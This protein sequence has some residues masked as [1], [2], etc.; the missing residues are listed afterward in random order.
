MNTHVAAKSTPSGN[1]KVTKA[2]W[3]ALALSVLV[4]D[5]VESVRIL[6]LSEKLK[7]SRSSFYW[8]FASHQDLLDQLLTHWREKNTRAIIER[9]R[10]AATTITHGVLNVFECWADEAVFSPRLDFAIREWAR[11]SDKARQEIERADRE[12][13]EAIRD[14]FL[15]HGFGAEEAFIRAR[16]LYYMQIGY[17]VL[18]VKEP[19][20]T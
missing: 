12:R 19:L 20:A 4:T 15:Q 3:I 10:R 2:D 6:S 13:L 8:Y 14:L 11:R 16:I 17:Y 1:V 7:V 9:A 18:D 5:G